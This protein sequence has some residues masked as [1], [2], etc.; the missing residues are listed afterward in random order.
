MAKKNEIVPNNIDSSV[1]VYTTADGSVQLNV[2]IDRDTVWL[3]L[4]QMAELFGRDKSVIG[5]HVRTLFREGE[6]QK[7][8]VWAKFAYTA[9]DGKVYQVDFYNLDVIIS[10]GYRVHS[11]RGTQFRIWATQVLKTYMLQ[12]AVI[13]PTWQE[14]EYHV[15]R[16]LE[17]QNNRILRLEARQDEQQHQLDFFIQ[18]STPPAEMVFMQ[19]EFFTARVALEKLIKTA[20]KRVVIVDNYVDAATFEMLD[21]RSCGVEAS[22]YTS[23]LGTALLRIKDLHN[24]QSGKEAIHIYQCKEDSHD[25]WIIV[26][27]SLYHCGPSLKDAGRKIGAITRM[28]TS[29]NEILDKIM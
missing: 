23:V 27:D 19:G 2:Q 11:L 24:A 26:D 7:D 5:K 6:L 16:Q 8:S 3:S 18:T 14:V 12:G 15:T 20:Q 13:R 28:G 21:V 9:S 17:E 25:R 1:V 10:V 22:I 4:D 29:P